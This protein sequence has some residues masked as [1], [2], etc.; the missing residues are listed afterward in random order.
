MKRT[1]ISSTTK[2]I[3]AVFLLLVTT[4]IC[5]YAEA[6]G[7]DAL[8]ERVTR[9]HG[10]SWSPDGTQFVIATNRGVEKEEV[11]L[12][13]KVSYL[14]L[15]GVDG[16]NLKQITFSGKDEQG[17]VVHYLDRN[18]RWSPN[19]KQIVFDSDR[20]EVRYDNPKERLTQIFLCEADGTNLHQISKGQGWVNN[21]QPSWHPNGQLLAWVTDRNASADVLLTDLAGKEIRYL[22]ADS[23]QREYYP[24]W[25][26]DGNAIAFMVQP[27][28]GDLPALGIYKRSMNQVKEEEI[29]NPLS[30]KPQELV[31][32]NSWYGLI[33]ICSPTNDTLGFVRGENPTDIWIV[34]LDRTGL[35]R[36]TD[37]QKQDL[38]ANYL[39]PPTWSPKGD[40]IAFIYV[41]KRTESPDA[42]ED[43]IY[44]CNIK[45]GSITEVSIPLGRTK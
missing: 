6:D 44:I 7:P 10:L 15:V 37:L 19:G 17:K 36:V 22:S 8:P 43:E 4:F 23:K 45:D 33:G 38:G 34:N 40:K 39:S 25:S 5:P 30:L 2:K 18:P 16:K 35:R 9:I 11:K 26:K 1:K 24:S 3:C 41:S 31:S 27:Q 20:G 14:W 12:E 32:V 28:Y 21:K 13:S 42:V 29:A